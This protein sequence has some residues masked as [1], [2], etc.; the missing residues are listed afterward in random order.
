MRKSSLPCLADAANIAMCAL[1]ALYGALV[2]A[3]MRTT[4]MPVYA[5][6]ALAIVF[7]ALCLLCSKVGCK[8]GLDLP[9]QPDKLDL[10]VFLGSFGFCLLIFLLYLFAYFPG[11]Y[12]SD[13]NSQWSQIHGVLPLSDW[14]PVLHT[15]LMGLLAAVCDH[16]AFVVFM[17]GVFYSAAV[18]YMTATLWQWRIHKPIC[19]GIAFLLSANIGISNIMAFPWKD[20]AFAI[21]TVVLATQLFKLH[22]TQGKWLNH[23]LHTV[24]LGLMLCLCG[25]LRHNGIALSLAAS[26]WL[27][28][29]FP[30][31]F[32]RIGISLLCFALFFFAV[33]GPL[34][35]AAGVEREEK[36]LEEM[37]GLPLT[38]LAH[39]YVEAP[40]SLEEDAT[41]LL[42]LLGPRDVYV[43][44]YFV[45]DWNSVKWELSFLP[46]DH[47]YS[48][49][50]VFG[51]MI[52]ACLAEPQL[53]MEA[54]GRLYEMSVWPSGNAYYAF[55]PYVDA[56]AEQFGFVSQKNPFLSR[57]LNWLCRKSAHAA[58]SWLFWKPGFYLL[59]IMLACCAYARRRPLSSLLLPA[60]LIAYHLVT[61]VML[62]SPTDFRFFLPTIMCAPIAVIGL[63]V[64]PAKSEK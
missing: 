56:S 40:E 5:F 63:I 9:V 34:Y 50:Q 35:S 26:V 32:K 38:V 61:C 15:L 54:M 19:I 46:P 51:M 27:T 24:A 12:S 43:E 55:A 44:K 47:G 20:C 2:V 28:L 8:F 7:Y 48:L 62:S 52:R 31:A 36:S 53:A 25:I 3:L 16:P 18:G 33:K 22:A 4:S 41:A 1:V 13:T 30:N 60:M 42:E 59:L 11:G 23:A 14:H 45:G 10:R 29:S 64:R 21:C 39:I 6:C 58:V 49:P 37:I 57:V 17:Q